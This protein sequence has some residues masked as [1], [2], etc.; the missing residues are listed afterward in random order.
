M[1]S[2]CALDTRATG[3]KS[4]LWTT[5]GPRTTSRCRG[6]SRAGS[7]LRY[8]VNRATRATA[9]GEPRDRREP[10]AIGSCCSTT[11]RG[12]VRVCL[13]SANA[14]AT[15]S[16]RSVVS[17]AAPTRMATSIRRR[18]HRPN[19]P[20]GRRDC[21]FQRGLRRA[22]SKSSTSTASATCSRARRSSGPDSTTERCWRSRTAAATGSRPIIACDRRAGLKVVYNPRM[23]ALHLAKPR[24][25]MSEV[26]LA[27]SSTRFGTPCILY[28]KH[29]GPFGK[30]RARRCG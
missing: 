6:R 20:D 23:L 9:I 24:P 29:Y 19:R 26:S 8:L 11:M 4:W 25:D 21:E 22:R 5:A 14:A 15:R 27:G 2:I 1:Q 3:W 30:K 17:A 13:P 28:L 12:R 10:Q 18:G 16:R 7:R